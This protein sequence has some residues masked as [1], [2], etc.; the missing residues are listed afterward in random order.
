MF[1]FSR[2]RFARVLIGL[3]CLCL[4]ACSG[5][6]DRRGI[7][8]VLSPYKIDKVQGNVVTREQLAAIKVG[9]PKTAVKDIL[10]TPLLTS[11]FHADRWD[12]VFTLQ[13]Q[14]IEPQMRRVAVF[15]SGDVL[16]RIE[17]DE[18]PS[19]AEFV[20]TLKSVAKTSDLP[21]MEA[22]PDSLQKFPV[23][24]PAPLEVP[25]ALPDSYPPLEAPRK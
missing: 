21:P 11:V 18:L 12:Y 4:V 9:M 15:F 22:T 24:K 23:P 8:V 20:A 2:F 10:G 25:G 13:R 3:T 19:E 7:A 5:I 1:D 17:A 6:S 14:G 16:S